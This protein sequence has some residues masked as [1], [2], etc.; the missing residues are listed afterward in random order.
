MIF[1]KDGDETIIWK[2]ISLLDTWSQARVP[3]EPGI[4]YKVYSFFMCN[5]ISPSTP[6]PG[7]ADS[8]QRG[9]QQWLGGGG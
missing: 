1:V 2:Y 8:H 4:D 5:N 3:I 6:C 9:H 7:H